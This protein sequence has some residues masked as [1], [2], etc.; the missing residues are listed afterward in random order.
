[1]F[2]EESPSIG[3]SNYSLLQLVK[4]LDKKR[5]EPVVLFAHRIESKEAFE[6]AGVRTIFLSAITGLQPQVQH[7][8]TGNIPWYKELSS[9]RFLWSAKRYIKEQRPLK[10]RLSRWLRDERFELIHT[11]NTV[12]DNLAFIAAGSDAH[13]PVVSHQR[14]YAK[15]TPFIRFLARNV[16]RFICVSR[17]VADYYI[18]SGLP[19]E[20]VVTIFNGIDTSVVKAVEKGHL[21]KTPVT[22]GWFGRL[23]TW[24]GTDTL[25]DAA[26]TI[27][28]DGTEARFVIAGTGP[29]EERIS[30]LVSSDQLLAGSVEVKGFVED[31]LKAMARCSI[32]V[33]SSIEP[34]PLSRSTIE[35]SAL[36]IPL[37]A[38]NIGGNP[39]IVED[40]VNGYLFNTGDP[41]SLAD[42]LSKLIGDPEKRAAFG[43]EAR[44]KAEKLFDASI[45]V[46]KISKLY[47]EIMIADG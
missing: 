1:M 28:S 7:T 33:N 35:A 14:G 30:K 2:V 41:A 29:E 26:R 38:S 39:E 46:E 19:E 34:E 8:A 5:F 32:V 42:A 23:E 37:V 45:H 20:K 11:N 31:A 12:S 27:L 17:N 16:R 9:Y 43:R 6:K 3:G 21:L 25:I 15:I 40:G 18:A 4:G 10:K 47:D 24:K 22:I 44:K 36:G 13:I